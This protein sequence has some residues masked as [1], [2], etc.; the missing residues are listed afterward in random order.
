ML[1]LK[2][3]TTREIGSRFGISHAMVVK[4]EKRIRTKCKMIRDEIV[5]G[6]RLPKK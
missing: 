1:T 3:L 6:K 2:E 5:E 4:I